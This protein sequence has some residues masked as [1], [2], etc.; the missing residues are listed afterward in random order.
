MVS[1]MS[2]T[3]NRLLR[4]GGYRLFG[5]HEW[6]SW[7]DATARGVLGMSGDEFESA[8]RS[9]TIA[10]SGEAKDLASMLPLIESLRRKHNLTGPT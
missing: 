5:L 1:L 6:T 4:R 2:T 7:L 3:E 9:G 8:Y 10:D